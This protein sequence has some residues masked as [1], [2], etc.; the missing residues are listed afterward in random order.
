MSS[1][2][3][4]GTASPQHS[5]FQR[6]ARRIAAAAASATLYPL[7]SLFYQV[8]RESAESDSSS[9]SISDNSR[10][11]KPLDDTGSSSTGSI[12]DD[13]TPLRCCQDPK[14]S[15]ASARRMSS[16]DTKSRLYDPPVC[17]PSSNRQHSCYPATGTT[18]RSDVKSYRVPRLSLKGHSEVFTPEN[19]CAPHTTSPPASSSR[20]Q[21]TL[22]FYSA[23]DSE[24][25]SPTPTS[26]RSAT[27]FTQL[28]GIEIADKSETA[29]PSSLSSILTLRPLLLAHRLSVKEELYLLDVLLSD[30][31]ASQF[32]PRERT[33]DSHSV[34]TP[35]RSSFPTAED[36]HQT[37]PLFHTDSDQC[38]TASSLDSSLCVFDQH[39]EA[40]IC[41]GGHWSGSYDPVTPSSSFPRTPRR[42]V[43]PRPSKPVSAKTPISRREVIAFKKQREGLVRQWFDRFNTVVFDN[44]LPSNMVLEWNPR[45]TRTAGQT[46]MTKT[47]GLQQRTARIHLSCRVVDC[48]ERLLTT[49][50]HEMCHA[51]QFLLEFEERPPHGPGFQK[52]AR[53]AAV[54]YADVP[55][56]VTH[57]YIVHQPKRYQCVECGHVYGRNSKLRDLQR[58]RCGKPTCQGSLIYLGHFNRDGTVLTEPTHPRPLTPYNRFIKDHFS[59]TKTANP[60][61]RYGEVMSMLASQWRS[62]KRDVMINSRREDNAHPS[63]MS[64]IAAPSAKIT[65]PAF[66]ESLRDQL[67]CLSLT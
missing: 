4:E 33:P 65:E 18:R 40:G 34:P 36:L 17:F 63:T 15:E 25:S 32:L 59:H 58:R 49:L 10:V 14:P 44:R 52:W 62:A 54:R 66:F 1:V 53:L 19:K 56:T 42:V 31:T 67:G 3:A 64:P 29:T 20:K 30:N 37:S 57:N 27:R 2:N 8:S 43:T 61:L 21:R 7:S 41:E 16:P 35:L 9:G 38:S 60:H 26:Q 47:A 55:V 23:T 46:I 13:S 45:L 24:S 28:L 5:L 48:E 51:A 39:K 11:S 22:L 6:S 50:L 12:S